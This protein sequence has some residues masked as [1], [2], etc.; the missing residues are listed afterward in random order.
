MVTNDSSLSL[1]FRAAALYPT[2]TTTLPAL[3]LVVDNFN[4]DPLGPAISSLT[5]VAFTLL[6]PWK[7]HKTSALPK[8]E[9]RPLSLPVPEGHCK[10]KLPSQVNALPEL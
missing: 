5:E 9:P 7:S 1:P 8:V 6:T 2:L 4:D 10:H 3:P